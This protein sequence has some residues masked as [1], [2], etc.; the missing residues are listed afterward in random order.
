MYYIGKFY[1]F[2]LFEEDDGSI[3]IGQGSSGAWKEKYKDI[4]EAKDQIRKWKKG[5]KYD[6][7]RNF[8]FN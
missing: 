3:R 7:E 5:V 4:E 8:R 6:Q 1:N 2:M